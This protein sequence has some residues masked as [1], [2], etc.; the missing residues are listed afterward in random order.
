MWST[1][2]VFKVAIQ[3]Y[4]GAFHEIAARNYFQDQPIEIIQCL[5]FEDVVA[6]VLKNEEDH[7]G[8]MAI[9]NTL[10]G[11]LMNNYRLL[12]ENNLKVVGEVFLRVKQHLIGLPGASIATLSEVHSHPMAIAQCRHYFKKYPAIRLVEAEDTALSVKRVSE[13]SDPSIGAIGSQ[14]AA[15]IYDLEILEDSIETDKK[16]YTRFL[17]LR[18]ASM[19]F[20]P[21]E[22]IEKVSISFS[23]GHEVGSLYKVLTVLAAYNVNLTKIQSAPIIGQP[24]EYMFFIDFVVEPGKITYLQALEAIKPLT[25]SLKVFGVYSQGK[26]YDG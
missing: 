3:G 5:T 24:W 9:E 22:K 16:N 7:V 17:V 8:L 6:H 13:Q 26:H 20:E 21:N 23:T 1:D 11:S 2:T 15:S 4:N 14:L 12:Q 18:D 10:G 19:D 25:N